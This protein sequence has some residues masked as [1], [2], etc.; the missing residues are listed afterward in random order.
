[1]VQTAYTQIQ[2][3]GMFLQNVLTRSFQ[4][5]AVF[6]D[7]Q[8]DLLHFLYKI[9]V[10]GYILDTT[11]SPNNIGIFPVTGQQSP[12]T[13]LGQMHSLFA[14]RQ[15]FL[16]TMQGG[17]LGS[18]T[19]LSAQPA[20]NQNSTSISGYDCKNGPKATVL[21]VDRFASDQ[22]IRIEVEFEI[23]QVQCAQDMSTPNNTGVLN[24]RWSCTDDTDENFY[25]TRTTAG[26]LRC[27]SGQINPH[28]FRGL[29][30]P[31]LQMGMRRQ[32]ISMTASADGLNLDYQIVDRE[33][34][35]APPAPATDWSLRVVERRT[36]DD[37]FWHT[38]VDVMLKGN[39]YADKKKLIAIASA[40]C[41]AKFSGGNPGANNYT[42]ESI[43]ISDEY[44]ANENSIHLSATARRNDN[45]GPAIKGVQAKWLGSPIVAADLGAVVT[46]YDSRL[47]PGAR[48][49]EPTGVDIK[50][51]NAAI[52]IFGA[53]STFVM[54]PCGGDYSLIGN[55]TPANSSTASSQN[56]LPQINALVVTELPDD[57]SLKYT[58]PGN[59]TAAY[60]YWELDSEYGTDQI[61]AHMPVAVTGFGSVGGGGNQTSV[62]VQ[63][64]PAGGVTQRV[65]RVVAERIGQLPALPN[66]VDNYTDENGNVCVLLENKLVGKSP[67]RSP[68]TKQIYRVA[69]ELVYAVTGPINASSQLRLGSNAWET[70]Q[71]LYKQVFPETLTV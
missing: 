66:P 54:G 39:R 28:S 1:M 48:Q 55:S 62:V 34:A 23:A 47:N 41:D 7:T 27:A 70:Q 53:F 44:S 36:L 3:G 40:I 60:T 18:V 32:S 58:D 24:N 37:I 52:P 15:P 29:V 50:A 19:L 14:P 68:D 9:R 8:T 16:M 63:L 6:D 71:P 56:P 69:G 26:R 11:T 65:I 30:I 43:T 12:P 2:Y 57:G 10:V 5:E 4:Q 38:D 35:F 59:S 49:N 25:T 17:A 31:P 20:V 51:S 13:Q 61:R 21:A 42:V 67:P 33:I 64:G 45:A 22:T 46:G